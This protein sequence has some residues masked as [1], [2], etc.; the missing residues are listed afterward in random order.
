[1]VIKPVRDGAGQLD[2]RAASRPS[3]PTS[4][5]PAGGQLEISASL[6]QPAPASGLGYWPAFWAMGAAAR[7]VGA[8]NWPSIGEMDIMEDVNA[9][10]Q[11]STTFHCGAV[12]GRVP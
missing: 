9:L 12:G 3:A 1:M 2:L 10:S 6:K 8:T 4:A 7:P 5:R 11:H